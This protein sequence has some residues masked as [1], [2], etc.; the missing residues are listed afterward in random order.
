[1]PTLCTLKG[2]QALGPPEADWQAHP[3]PGPLPFQPP[4]D[5]SPSSEC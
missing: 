3:V 5:L 4:G 1:M 2:K